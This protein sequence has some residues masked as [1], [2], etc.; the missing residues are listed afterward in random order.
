VSANLFVT[1]TSSGSG[2]TIQATS[3]CAANGGGNG[4]TATPWQDTCIQAAV[5]AAAPG[6][7][8]QLA[9]GHW[10]FSF[11]HP[12]ISIT[13]GINVVGAGSGNIFDAYGHPQNGYCATL[14]ASGGNFDCLPNGTFTR[15]YQASGCSGVDCQPNPPT[16]IM[17]FENC[18]AAPS[19]S[20]V[21]IDGSPFTSG[22]DLWG[23]VNFDHCNGAVVND[24]RV[25]AYSD[26]TGIN[27]ECQFCF[28][29]SINHT[30]KNS[31]FA[32]APYINGSNGLYYGA[33]TYQEQSQD[34]EL[35]QNNLFYMMY[36]NP[37]Q[38]DDLTF[39]GNQAFMG[40]D[41]SGGPNGLS[42]YGSSG[43][44]PAANWYSG[45]RTGTNPNCPYT[46]SSSGSG[47]YC[48]YAVNN[49]FN[50]IGS[51]SLPFGLGVGINDPSANGISNLNTFAGNWVLGTHVAIDSCSA[52]I[53]ANPG[54]CTDGTVG[55][56]F[57]GMQVNGFTATNN[58]LIGTSEADLNLTGTGTVQSGH[59]NTVTGAVAQNNYFSSPSN[60]YITDS[61]NISPIV[62]GNYCS[63]SSASFSGCTT[64]GFTTP[65][66]CSFS[67]GALSGSTVPFASTAFTAQYGA[68]QY[69]ASTSSTTPLSNDSR[70]NQTGL[71][72][73]NDSYIP[74]VSLT[75]VAHGNSVYM[76][77]MDSAN[78][79]GSCGS[80]IVN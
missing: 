45:T 14:G 53:F 71:N 8:V 22:G 37:F 17:R 76:W 42:Q 44:G 47:S 34:Q 11:S 49:L 67:L 15:I 4:T 79:I 41:A 46:S 23:L 50:S 65:P 70:W 19:L 10:A 1:V 48:T 72:S 16:G 59:V 12:Y 75:P 73:G 28:N 62:S 13:K 18:T 38:E 63:G 25:W 27:G 29:Q 43:T 7:T 24:V 5:S 2:N 31:V 78:H 64:S 40:Y 74:P 66:T 52:H 26:T 58:S 68:V 77:V 20:H 36:F 33:Q 69:L 54:G 3:Y 6:D 80:A 56:G 55:G 9:A 61:N 51:T 57:E 39:V 35:I 60:Q 30:V 21:F 32:F